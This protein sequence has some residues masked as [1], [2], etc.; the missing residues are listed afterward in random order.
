[1]TQKSKRTA[2]TPENILRVLSSKE[3]PEL[4]AKALLARLG[5]DTR[6]AGRLQKLL[7]KLER[8]G[9]LEAEGQKYRMVDRE[10]TQSGS[11]RSESPVS[12]EVVARW[13]LVCVSILLALLVSIA[14]LPGL[15]G[16]FLA[17]DDPRYVTK[18]SHIQSFS[19]QT[20]VWAFT[21]FDVGNWHPL[22]WLSLVLDHRIYGLEPF[23]YHMTSLII[24]VLNSIL[25]FLV[26]YRLTGHPWR[27]LAVA[28]LFALHPLRVES[29]SW[30]SE[31]KDVL[32]AFFWL[33]TMVAY[34]RYVRMKTAASYLL[35][36]ITFAMG[37]MS[38]PVVVTLPA[39]LLL[40]DYWPLR[41]LNWRAVW[42]KLPLFAL[43]IVCVV[44]TIAAQQ[45]GG[46]VQIDSI[47]LFERAANSLVAYVHYLVLTVWPSDLSPWYSHPSLEGPSLSPWY[48]LGATVFILGV[49]ALTLLWGN[50]RRYLPVGWFW[51]LGTLVPMI[52]L[53]QVGR[54]GMA[55][56]YTY[57]PHI[58]LFLLI[59]WVIA[60][61]PVWKSLRLRAFG[62]ALTAGLVLTLS[63]L[64]W[65]QTMIW[66][67]NLTLWSYTVDRSPYA[68]IAHQAL[69]LELLRL[70]RYDE[71]LIAFERANS[72]RPEIP[73]VHFK[74]GALFSHKRD[75]NNA[76][77]HFRE[78][79]ALQPDSAR[80][81]HSL[82]KTFLK[83]GQREEARESVEHALA[84]HPGYAEA[85]NTLGQILLAEGKP[86]E[87]VREFRAALLARPKYSA[88]RRYLEKALKMLD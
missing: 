7:R 46:A 2:V 44:L 10:P 43:S 36:V 26:L 70:K 45:S 69:G 77:H 51:F 28:V 57:I 37:L 85:H 61:L 71:A 17:W 31:R 67:S 64:T 30:V 20:V 59:V 48:V 21:S 23:G 1:M 78:A 9:I 54:Q 65:R 87:A 42:E 27:S 68:F 4:T 53:L 66:H 56:R 63:A 82:A 86:E 72:I 41:R 39:A 34:A 84:L 18:N 74:L 75:F 81:H 35:V 32:S 47:P 8:N 52:G 29:V 11:S 58:G 33:L 38:K 14:F 49:T 12:K 55:D 19:W 79:V 50:R 62:I 22:T 5:G 6:S 3:R 83:M 13:K 40:L 60:E 76:V 88:A 80:Y 73:Q 25:V 24:H 15:D 16:E